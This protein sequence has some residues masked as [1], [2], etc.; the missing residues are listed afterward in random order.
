MKRGAISLFEVAF[1]EAGET[2]ARSGK[3]RFGYDIVQAK[4]A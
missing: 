4:K 2:N 3:G 1:T